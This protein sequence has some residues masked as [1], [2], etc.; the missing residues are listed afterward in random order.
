[1]THSIGLNELYA[2]FTLRGGQQ[3]RE[4]EELYCPQ[5]D[6]V[7]QH[8]KPRGE[9][10]EIRISSTMSCRAGHCRRGQELRNWRAAALPARPLPWWPR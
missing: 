4:R 8:Q 10:A 1:M 3:V 7:A 6:L 9:L 2:Q 5:L